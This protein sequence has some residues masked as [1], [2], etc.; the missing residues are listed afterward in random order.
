MDIFDMIC[1]DLDQALSEKHISQD[2]ATAI[3][4]VLRLEA[5]GREDEVML[6][7][8]LLGGGA[9]P[10]SLAYL[11]DGRVADEKIALAH[12]SGPGVYSLD[13]PD[14]EA[15]LT[16]CALSEDE[17]QESTLRSR[18][19]KYAHSLRY[20]GVIS[21]GKTDDRLLSEMAAAAEDEYLSL[22]YAPTTM[23]HPDKAVRVYASD[24][25]HAAGVWDKEDPQTA[26]AV[27]GTFNG[28]PYVAVGA[29]PYADTLEAQG[30]E[31]MI[32]T[33]KISDR[34]WIVENEAILAEVSAAL[35]AAS[36]EVPGE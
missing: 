22:P 33:K 8:R 15:Y 31:P 7:C 21:G 10:A 5:E 16:F 3:R 18:V 29:P 1:G 11:R 9:D 19:I 4:E 20:L 35:R 6:A 32:A 27:F 13:D 2:A 12:R 36:I 28:A 25:G 34:F 26:T 17:A 30:F 24:G 14:R 23:L